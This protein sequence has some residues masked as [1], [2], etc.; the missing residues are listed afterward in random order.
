MLVAAAATIGV[1]HASSPVKKFP[2][3]KNSRFLKF[4]VVTVCALL[5]RDL[6]AIAKF[7]VE[8]QTTKPFV[9]SEMAFESHSRSA[10]MSFFARSPGFSTKEWKSRLRSLSDKHS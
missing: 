3:W 4:T 5:T 6:L 8:I 9:V 1:P 10:A 7:L 2:T